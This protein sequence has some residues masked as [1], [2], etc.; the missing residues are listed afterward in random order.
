MAQNQRICYDY[1]VEVEKMN[2]NIKIIKDKHYL[3]G[4]DQKIS[5]YYEN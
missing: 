3:S 1:S 4:R 5:K 2:E